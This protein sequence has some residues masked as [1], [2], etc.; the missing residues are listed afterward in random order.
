MQTRDIEPDASRSTG[1]DPHE[2]KAAM[3][4]VRA[5]IVG[6]HR[7]GVRDRAIIAAL[8]AELLPRLVAAFGPDGAASI[9]GSLASGIS[10]AA[11][12]PPPHR[13]Q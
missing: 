2:F 7:A 9:L 4:Q 13:R 3:D 10:E 12:P 5:G 11:N 6:C 8:T 1:P